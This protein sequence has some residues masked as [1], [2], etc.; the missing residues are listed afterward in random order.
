[1]AVREEYGSEIWSEMWRE[2]LGRIRKITGCWRKP[3]CKD[4][5]EGLGLEERITQQAM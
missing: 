2:Y 3:K 1:M 4:Y 5:F